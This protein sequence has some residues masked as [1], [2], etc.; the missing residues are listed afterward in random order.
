MTS[1]HTTRPAAPTRSRFRWRTVDLITTAM[2][3][4][5][6][7]VIF[8]GWGQVYNLVDPLTKALPPVSGL[9]GGFWWLPAVVAALV[10]RRPGAALLA[11]VVAASVEP[12]LGGQWGLLTLGSGL[13]QGLGV[14]LGFLIFA[15]RRWGWL[16]AALGGLLA[17]LL[18]TPFEWAT[19]YP[20][21][22]AGWAGLYAITMGL[23][24]MVLG[25]LL[26]WVLTRAL[27]GTGALAPFPVG[28]ERAEARRL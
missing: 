6:F 15:Y 21:W 11:E 24:G 10:T 5:A 13:I 26:G 3:G 25:G 23:S 16:P 20:S 28:R 12:L 19:Y 8:I 4:V 18:E 7:G 27:A 14:E 1:T 9:L 17:G 2:I 22:S